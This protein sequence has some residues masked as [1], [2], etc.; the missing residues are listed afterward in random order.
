MTGGGR[1]TTSGKEGLTLNFIT[2]GGKA[3]G[4]VGQGTWYL[5]EDPA[6]FQTE[7]AALRAGIEAGMTLIDTAEMYGGGAAERLVGASIQGFGREELYLVSKVFPHNAGRRN[8]F[9]SCEASL[10]RMGT[11]YLDL[12]LLHWRGSIPLAETVECM[13][14]LREKG[15]IRAWGVSNLDTADMKE[16]LRVRGGGDCAANQVLYHLGSRGIEF[17][18]V[19]LLREHHI[20]VMA[21]CPLAQA[22]RLRRGLLESPAVREIAGARGVQPAQVLL[23]FLLAQ[24]GVMP[25]PRTGRAEHTLENA[26][27]AQLRLSDEELAALDRA[28]PAPR[29]KVPLD[30]Q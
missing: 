3:A 13:E 7:Q 16:L 17:D 21:Y 12:Y 22:G 6:A 28:F 14:Q 30:I 5:G 15:R 19:P 1:S 2:A 9:Q 8:I 18:L 25:I 27:A 20:P 4:P 23:A 29:H 11:E 26:A 10:R 24:P